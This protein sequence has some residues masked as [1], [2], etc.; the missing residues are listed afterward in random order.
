MK[1][2]GGFDKP[3]SLQKPV[4]QTKCDP[5]LYEYASHWTESGGNIYV[6]AAI[7]KRVNQVLQSELC[8]HDLI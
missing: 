4:V 6:N 8:M 1:T 7:L 5:I 3:T 2:A